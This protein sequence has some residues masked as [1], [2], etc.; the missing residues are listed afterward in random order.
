MINKGVRAKTYLK[1]M[2]EEC[3]LEKNVKKKTYLK[4]PFKQNNDI[5]WKLLYLFF[6]I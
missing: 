6:S 1:K 3:V 5:E 2:K 4:N